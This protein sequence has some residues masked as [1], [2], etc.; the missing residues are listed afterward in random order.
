M[1][2]I[3][4]L[5]PLGV[6]STMVAAAPLAT[7]SGSIMATP[8]VAPADSLDIR[9]LSGNRDLSKREEVVRL[10]D[11]QKQKQIQ[12]DMKE[13][14][15]VLRD[16]IFT[17]F[18]DVTEIPT[19]S[20]YNTL[21]ER[22]GEV[23]T[24]MFNVEKELDFFRKL[25]DEMKSAFETVKRYKSCSAKGVGFVN[26]MLVLKVRALALFG[27]DGSPDTS[28]PDYQTKLSEVVSALSSL[29][30]EVASANGLPGGFHIPFSRH[31]GELKANIAVLK[32][33]SDQKCDWA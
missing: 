30:T 26:D 24:T 22:G 29:E 11:E 23:T 1:K 6:F 33:E 14:T 2:S 16:W 25:L 20:L 18:D 3:Q 13:E 31:V 4:L 28:I 9:D 7:I 21:A 27:P 32:G 8:S 12:K 19:Y 10:T 17:G 15:D 5:F